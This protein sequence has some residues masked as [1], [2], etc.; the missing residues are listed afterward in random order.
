MRRIEDERR[1]YAECK[2]GIEEKMR[3]LEEE[4]IPFALENPS[5][6]YF[7]EL[8]SVKLRM[9]KMPGWRLHEAD[10]LRNPPRY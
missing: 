5:G 3:A 7:W 6:S 8:D 10:S 4:Q 1:M 9:E 2:Q